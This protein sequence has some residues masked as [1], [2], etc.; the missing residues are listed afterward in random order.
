MGMIFSYNHFS[1]LIRGGK[2]SPKEWG[3]VGNKM[4]FT[5]A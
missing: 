2:K 3:D 4:L 5:G 1:Y